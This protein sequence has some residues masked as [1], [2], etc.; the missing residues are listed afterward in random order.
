MN[1]KMGHAYYL[2]KLV[3]RKTCSFIHYEKLILSC[4]MYHCVH[5]ENP[6]NSNS[7]RSCLVS[8]G[9]NWT[10]KCLRR[11]NTH[12]PTEEMLQWIMIII[13]TTFKSTKILESPLAGIKTWSAA[14]SSSFYLISSSPFPYESTIIPMFHWKITFKALHF[15]NGTYE[16]ETLS[17]KPS[18]TT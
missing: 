8:R 14:C 5:L 4:E 3:H 13:S 2:A 11:E 9:S 17:G 1:F 12:C 16:G 15:I 6:V 7:A 18:G 10:Q